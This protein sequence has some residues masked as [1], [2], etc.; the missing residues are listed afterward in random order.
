MRTLKQSLIRIAVLQACFIVI[1]QTIW[2]C[3]CSNFLPI[4]GG[5]IDEAELLEKRVKQRP[6]V[7]RVMR[8]HGLA[9]FHMDTSAQPTSFYY[10]SSGF[11]KMGKDS[12]GR[13][14]TVR[15]KDE[16]SSEQLEI[17]ARAVALEALALHFPRRV[18]FI[19]LFNN[20]RTTYI[21]EPCGRSV[22]K[23]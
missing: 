15:I 16:Y 8:E 10:G 3:G 23:K 17:L 5:E 20:M 6:E 7:I 9:T 2:F 19:D 11:K 4:T 22:R 1:T 21:I 18:Q 12:E 14:V 13:D